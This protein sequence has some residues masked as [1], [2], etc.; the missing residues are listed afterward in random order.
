MLLEKVWGKTASK[1]TLDS[2]AVI[3]NHMCSCETASTSFK[4][5]NLEG[6]QLRTVT[7]LLIEVQKH[8]IQMRIRRLGCHVEYMLS[9]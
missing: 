7:L 1:A 6:G 2:K 3:P 8:K 5:S 9:C 4:L